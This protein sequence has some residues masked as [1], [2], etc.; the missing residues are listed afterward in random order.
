MKQSEID[1]PTTDGWDTEV[2]NKR[3]GRHLKKL[4]HLLESP[5]E[6]DAAHV[7]PLVTSNFR[8]ASLRPEARVKVFEDEGLTVHR[9]AE[10]QLA[11]SS[12]DAH[13]GA[14]G[15][16]QA[17][18]SLAQGFED[19]SDVHTK[20]KVVRIETSETT[21]AATVYF[22]ASGHVPGGSI[23]RN[24]TWRCTWTADAASPRLR[25]IDVLDYEEVSA[26]SASGTLFS[27]CTNSVL[28]RV[29]IY[30]E[31]LLPSIHHWLKRVDISVALDFEG[32]QGLAVGDVNGDGLDDLYVCQGGGLPNRLLVHEPDGTVTEMSAEAG[33][34]WI[35]TTRSA[36]LVDL[37]NDGDQDLAV[38]TDDQVILLANDGAG[39]FSERS[40][41]PDLPI[42]FSIAAADY[43][44]DAD[45]DLY[46]C[47][48]FA[49][50][51]K[52]MGQLPHPVPYHDA[53]N[54]GA[55]ALLRNDGDWRFVDAT[56]ETGL[57]ANNGRWSYA[58]AWEDYDNDGDVDLYVANDFG[59]NNLYRNDGG[60][61]VDV[62]AAAGVEDIASGMSV[63]WADYNHDG[64]MDLY[65]SNMFSSAGGRIT[66]QRQ[67][68]ETASPQTKS[69]YQ[70]L[71][72]GN[73][74]FRNLGD[75]TFDDV[76]DEAA[77]T[78]GRWAWSSNFVDINN[79][80]WDDLVVANGYVTGEDTGDL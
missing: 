26:R 54:G 48:Y 28:S 51:N 12:A 61:F 13:R 10:R 59:R 39:H 32:M 17:M 63:S 24:A 76:S 52:N 1:D 3:L 23:E 56:R 79:D 9:A 73:S 67:F 33:V 11:A 72:R 42:G 8:C 78:M 55:N 25:S 80:G 37:D 27:D 38:T 16:V 69:H 18:R 41:W 20:T 71:A 70:R 29:P 22:S 6:I 49:D 60:R 14:S 36:L 40:R 15:L 50:T 34:D 53:N 62:A 64:W 57:D 47:R 65:V 21:T 5:R 77:V 66:Y 2:W 35:E 75:G 45:L 46:V 58:A 44:E 4:I 43:D 19:A 7:S 30:E 68:Q 31:Q 74:L